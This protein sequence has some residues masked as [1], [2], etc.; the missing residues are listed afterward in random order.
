MEKTGIASVKPVTVS[1]MFE[2]T[3]EQ[4][5]DHPAL[6]YKEEGEWKTVTYKQYYNTCIATAKSFLKVS[7]CIPMHF[8]RKGVVARQ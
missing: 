4:Y 7:L 8:S 3:V 5:P 1:Q 2:K 6:S